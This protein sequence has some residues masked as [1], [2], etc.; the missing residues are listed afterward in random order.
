MTQMNPAARGAHDL[1]LAAWFGGSLMGA[2]G[3]NAAASKVPQ[4]QERLRVANAAWAAWTPVNLAAI[5]LHAAGAMSILLNN[6]KRLATQQQVATATAIKAALTFGALGATAYA[7]LLGQR[8]MSTNGRQPDLRAEGAVEPAPD[9]PEEVAV[10]Q[11]QLR[12][13]Q[14]AIPALTGG[15]LAV[16]AWMGEQ[17]R[18]AAVASGI[19]ARLLPHSL[20][21]GWQP[22]REP[23][24][25]DAG[26]ASRYGPP[27]PRLRRRAALGRPAR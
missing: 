10:A 11:R 20:A 8:L 27:R 23:A 3:V 9:T 12:I 17:Q 14:W 5:G 19:A 2:I 22:T 1:G 6:R 26:L 15:A 4:E 16:S 18:P 24:R 21:A 7:R 25:A 13:L